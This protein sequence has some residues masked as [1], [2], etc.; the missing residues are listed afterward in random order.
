MYP[1]KSNVDYEINSDRVKKICILRPDNLGDLILF[2][3]VIKLLKEKFIGSEIT[4][5]VKNYTRD[6]L[7]RQ[8]YIDKVISWES[9]Y[10]PFTNRESYFKG[11][12]LLQNFYSSIR[13][14]NE[15]NIL[16]PY[17]LLIMPVRTP[18][19]EVHLFSKLL[20]SKNKVA[21]F[22][23]SEAE[24]KE[25]KLHSIYDHI[26]QSKIEIPFTHEMSSSLELLKFLG[27]KAEMKDIMPIFYT[28]VHHKKWAELNVVNK[29]N[30]IHIGIAPGVTSKPD[31][32]YAASNYKDIFDKLASHTFSITIFG[33]K[34]EHE[35]CSLVE[36]I[37][38]QLDNI[39]SI[40]NLCGKTTLCQLT[41]AMKRCDLIVSSETASLHLATALGLPVV[42]IVGGGHYGRFYPWGD[43]SIQLVATHKMD[44]F[45]CNWKCVHDEKY[46]IH[47]IPPTEIAEL[48]DK[49]IRRALPQSKKN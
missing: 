26:I 25:K 28:D 3:G 21:L 10:L 34:S 44:C 42:G 24:I 48:I 11:K 20:I 18:D 39:V 37:L 40:Q 30:S 13:I 41:E 22:S 12:W 47:D 49:L 15:N 23:R 33:S 7:E 17:D 16:N 6:L 4:L 38:H 32:F 36:N 45:Y 46:C 2:S 5:F 9:L 14:F 19:D 35:Q 27:I 31:K 29:S 1:Q 43:S 8:P